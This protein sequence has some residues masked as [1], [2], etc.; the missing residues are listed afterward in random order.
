MTSRTRTFPAV[1]F[2]LLACSRPSAEQAAAIKPP[3]ALTATSATKNAVALSWTPG[4][5]GDTRFLVERKPLGASWTPPPAPKPSPI[6]TINA[7]GTSTRDDRVDARATYVYRVRVLNA[8]GAASAPSNE[9]T[10]GPPPVGFSQIV[11]SPPSETQPGFAAAF[12]VALD[13][14]DDPAIAF[15]VEDPDNNSD[16]ADS[17]LQFLS[18]SRALYRWNAPVMIG[19]IGALDKS[20]PR[21]GLSLARDAVAN[22]LGIAYTASGD[23]ELRVA[24]SE[25]GA[26]WRQ[27]TIVTGEEGAAGGPS[28][29]LHDGRIYLAYQGEGDEG[30]RALLF[31]SGAQTDAPGKWQSSRAPLLDGT[32]DVRRAGV[33]VALDAAGRPAIAYWLNPSEGYNV[34]AAFWRPG[35]PAATKVTDT[36]GFQS[37]TV[38]LRLAFSGTAPSVLVYARRDERFFDNGNQIWFVRS[39]GDG[40]AWSAPVP[41]PNDGGNSMGFPIALA[42]D[43]AGRPAVTAQVDGGNNGET[44][45][46]QPKILRPDAAGRWT[47]C[48]PDTRGTPTHEAKLPSI[49]TVGDALMIVFRADREGGALKAGLVLWRER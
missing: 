19:R 45:C 42:F 24:F 20:A 40:K 17:T 22:R 41:L 49:H 18:W 14:N 29:A 2:A 9:I 43:S 32:W 23:R 12:S 47:I 10:V 48:A 4:T 46:G 8:A 3:S 34:A 37:D 25:D 26:A 27:V 36:A 11:P 31:K 13:A 5:A 35:E 28:L 33:S 7:E 38:D 30:R 44:R 39:T 16:P 1:L 15:V 21:L 6:V